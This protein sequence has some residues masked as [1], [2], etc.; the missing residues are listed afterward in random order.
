MVTPVV[1]HIGMSK[2]MSTTLQTIWQSDSD[3]AFGSL[4]SQK[5]SVE[6]LIAENH[7]NQKRVEQILGIPG[8]QVAVKNG[9]PNVF[10]SEGVLNAFRAHPDLARFNSVK[11]E[12]FAKI[13][14]TQASDLFVVV[15]KP[16][17]WVRSIYGQH[18]REGGTADLANYLEKY[19]PFLEE[20]LNLK[21]VLNIWESFGYKVLILPLELSNDWEKFWTLY[22][23]NLNISRPKSYCME[24]PE[25]VQNKTMRDR[26]P[27]QRAVNHV[28]ELL[29][30][31][32]SSNPLMVP[33]MLEQARR[34]QL[35]GSRVCL[36]SMD[37]SQIAKL[38]ACLHPDLFAGE[39]QMF[40]PQILMQYLE[41]HIRDNFMP[42]VERFAPPECSPI[43][44]QYV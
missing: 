22:E 29:L 11:Q 4:D 1:L 8:V 44:E 39:H 2:C 43:L 38:R 3:Y 27:V 42:A 5:T 21:K 9:R 6:N 12:I 30:E 19:L 40:D 14:A 41:T 10:S 37:K 35:V 25:A 20:T 24:L 23:C 26:L 17:E 31:A 33:S 13:F 15:R 16:M 7:G 32:G 18:I 34:F 28:T 36:E